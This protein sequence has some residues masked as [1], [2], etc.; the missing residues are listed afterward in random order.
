MNE[1]LR[2]VKPWYRSVTMWMGITQVL[3]GVMFML[4]LVIAVAHGHTDMVNLLL[5]A[6]GAMLTTG[7][8]TLWGR[9]TAK[10]KVKL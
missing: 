4:A 1:P 5:T 7:I 6:G 10:Q 3:V 8:G 2:G 9:S